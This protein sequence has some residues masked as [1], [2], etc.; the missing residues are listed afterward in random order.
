MHKWRVAW[1]PVF[2]NDPE[3]PVAWRWA[4]VLC[5]RSVKVRPRTMRVAHVQHFAS[6]GHRLPGGWVRD[7]ASGGVGWMETGALG[8]A[9]AYGITRKTTCC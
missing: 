5:R 9:V 6:Q 4:A 1:H 2:A 3:R 7:N 8:P